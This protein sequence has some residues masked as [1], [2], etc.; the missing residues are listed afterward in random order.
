VFVLFVAVSSNCATFCSVTCP[1][2]RSPVQRQPT[3]RY[4]CL[5]TS[6]R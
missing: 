3:R 5:H 6:F 4:S 2:I 1:A